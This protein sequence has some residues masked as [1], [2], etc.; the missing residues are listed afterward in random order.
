M[1]RVGIDFGTSTTLVAYRLSD[2]SAPEI[3]PIG[4]TVPWIPSVVTESDP[5]LV[6]EDA[7]AR[8]DRKSSVKSDLTR[9][10]GAG[11]SSSEVSRSQVKAIMAEAVA[12]AKARNKDIF[13]D[14]KVFLGC[15]ALWTLTNRKMIADIA[16]ELNL[17]VD[18]AN[19]IDE[20]VAA[21]VQ[22]SNNQLFRG[23]QKL[24]NGKALIFDAGGGTLDIAFLHLG[25]EG[26][27]SSDKPEVTVLSAKSLEQAGDSLDEAVCE[28]LRTRDP[29]LADQEAGE[30][31]LRRV[32]RALKEAL[33]FEDE[34]S[35]NAGRPFSRPI[36]LTRN[37]LESIFA[38]QLQDS[39]DLVRAVVK[40]SL[41]RN[42]ASIS[43]ID[44]REKKY[45][46][47]CDDVKF[48][49]LVGGFSSMPVF[50]REL[51]KS[52]KKAEFVRLEK[53]QQAV[54]EGLTYGD[55][56][57]RLNMPRPPLSFFIKSK[58]HKS[59]EICVYQAFSEVYHQHDLFQGRSYLST[60]LDLQNLGSGEFSFWCEIPDRARTRVPFLVSTKQGEKE[61]FETIS[62]T[63]D[64]RS[65]SGHLI[66]ILYTTG[67]ICI[68]GLDKQF[69]LRSKFWPRLADGTDLADIRLEVERSTR[70]EFGNF[71][72]EWWRSK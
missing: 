14:A 28:Y 66:F 40:E 67:E 30:K 72:L 44:V 57:I 13:K 17:D 64:L 7:E 55:Q 11:I 5:M 50:E 3:L 68:Q 61:I 27:Q 36:V 53:P 52:F 71:D 51:R 42:K 59:E 22:W 15:P 34:E 46:E 39:M 26:S 2:S 70:E 16:N 33:S 35:V 8:E 54:A 12:R 37:E 10:Q 45:T 20:P 25:K 56:Y 23:T 24:P 1:K 47:L 65:Q 21:G 6:G 29:D 38:T 48:V 19:V 41:F 32:S 63:Q 18:I 4:R 62:I 31:E 49:V 43:A 9:G 58:S 69:L 60:R